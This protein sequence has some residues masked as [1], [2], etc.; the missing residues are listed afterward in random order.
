M[1]EKF[2]DE[3]I[4][5]DIKH[6]N[7]DVC[8][9][10]NFF[11]RDTIKSKTGVIKVMV[12]AK[13]GEINGINI[14]ENSSKISCDFSGLIKSLNKLYDNLL[15]GGVELRVIYDDFNCNNINNIYGK[16][17]NPE[18][19]ELSYSLYNNSHKKL[20]NVFIDQLKYPEL[21]SLVIDNFFKNNDYLQDIK[22]IILMLYNDV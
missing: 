1:N 14:Y 18:N 17:Y 4:H 12:L 13:T 11:S 9:N 16:I 21:V 5:I 15:K 20:T 8:I 3:N 2:N 22:N 6:E 19:Y 10:K 7:L